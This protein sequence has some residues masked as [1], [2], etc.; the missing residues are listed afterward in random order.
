MKMKRIFQ[1]GLSVIGIISAGLMFK[2]TSDQ[3]ERSNG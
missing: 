2:K 3:S 1:I